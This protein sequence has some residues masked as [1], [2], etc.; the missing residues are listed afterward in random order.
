MDG[1]PVQLNDILYCRERRA[2]IQSD[3]IHKYHCPVISFSM[4]I[5]GPIKTTPA[6]RKAFDMGKR[7]LISWLYSE[8]ISIAGYTELHEITGDE[9]IMAVDCP[10][11]KL[12]EK[13]VLIEETPPLGRLY[14]IDIIDE[15]GTKLSRILFRKCIICEKPAYECARSRA[16]SV[17][18][19]QAKIEELL[20]S[21]L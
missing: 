19:L 9:L 14:D 11:E 18:E 15:T 7:E 5:P 8:Q 16:H 17:E 2:H 3:Y 10:A 13:A 4:N 21:I 12:K 6:F 20:D 1:I